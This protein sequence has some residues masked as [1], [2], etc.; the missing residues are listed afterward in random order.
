MRGREEKEIGAFIPFI[1]LVPSLP[2]HCR[3]FVAFYLGPQLL[4]GSLLGSGSCSV[5]LLL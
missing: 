4:S 3:S 5:L 2:S 1:T